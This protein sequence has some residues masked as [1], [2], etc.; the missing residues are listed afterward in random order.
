MHLLPSARGVRPD[1]CP[2]TQQINSER[3]LTPDIWTLICTFAEHG[4][5]LDRTVE[6][7]ELWQ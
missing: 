3:L 2:K 5:F 4:H 7:E 1:F 6:K